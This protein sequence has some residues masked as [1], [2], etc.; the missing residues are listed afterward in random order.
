AAID[1]NGNVTVTPNSNFVGTVRV[2]VTVTDGAEST[3]LPFLFTVTDPTPTLSAIN[4]L[5]TS[6]TLGGSLTLGLGAADQNPNDTV[7][8]SAGL[9]DPLY[10]LEVKYDLT[11]LTGYFNLRGQGEWYFQSGNGGNPAGSGI[12]VLM[13][14]GKLYAYAAQP[15]LSLTDTLAKAP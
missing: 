3:Q 8:L 13:P 7:T 9:D 12:F 5:V 10:D 4:S 15:G 11:L 6:S 1:S 2:T 14:S